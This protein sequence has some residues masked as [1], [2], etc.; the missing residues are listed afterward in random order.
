MD[1]LGVIVMFGTIALIDIPSIVKKSKHRVKYV[2]F[3]A[4]IIGIG[5]AISLLQVSGKAPASPAKVIESV[6]KGIIGEV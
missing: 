1:I 3:Y 4:F 6:I 5:F 2:G